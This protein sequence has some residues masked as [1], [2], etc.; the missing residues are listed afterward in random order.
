MR[1]APPTPVNKPNAAPLA[2][3]TNKKEAKILQAPTGQLQSTNVS[4]NQLYQ[5]HKEQQQVKNEDLPRE[6]FHKDDVIRWWKTI[7]HSLKM[8]NQDQVFLIMT[9]RD[10][11]QIDDLNFLFETD[12]SIQATRLE[13]MMDE[14]MATLRK[15]VKNYDIVIKISTAEHVEEDVKFLTGQDKFEKLARKNSNLFDLKNRFNL[16]IEG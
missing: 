12:N 14:I 9:K 1:N 7:A 5:K 8:K 11:Q 15:E 2:P 4:I 3:F 13:S 16:D 10:P 6:A